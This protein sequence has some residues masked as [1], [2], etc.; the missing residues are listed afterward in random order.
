MRQTIAPAMPLDN[1]RREWDRLSKQSVWTCYG[2]TQRF[3]SIALLQYGT[4]SN[5]VVKAKTGSQYIALSV[6]SERIFQGDYSGGLQGYLRHNFPEAHKSHV[7]IYRMLGVLEKMGVLRRFS[8]GRGNVGNFLVNPHKAIAALLYF[9]ELL[10]LEPVHAELDGDWQ[11]T[12]KVL[13]YMPDLA[14]PD[15]SKWL[16]YQYKKVFGFLPNRLKDF[17]ELTGDVAVMA[18]NAFEEFSQVVMDSFSVPSEYLEDHMS[19]CMKFFRKRKPIEPDVQ[20]E[21]ED[22]W[23]MSLDELPY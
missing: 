5:W 6:Q 20:A 19:Y 8:N 11:L 22:L 2:I 23:E 1:R 4:F 9:E 12:D 7:S 18:A 10:E 17:V 3:V 13:E 14:V 21:S 16:A 15:N